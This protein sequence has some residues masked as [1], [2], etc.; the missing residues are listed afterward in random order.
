MWL[1]MTTA[2]PRSAAI[3]CSGASTA[4]TSALLWASRSPM[5]APS[6]SST[7]SRQSR[8]ASSLP[9]S[10]G[11]ASSSVNERSMTFPLRSIHR[12]DSRCSI[13]D[14]SAPAWSRRGTTVSATSSSAPISSTDPRGQGAEPS[15]QSRPVLTRAAMSSVTKLLPSPGSPNSSVIFPSATRPGHSQRTSRGST[16][17]KLIVRACGPNVS[18]ALCITNLPCLKE[19]RPR[20]ACTCTRPR[21]L[22]QTR[23]CCAGETRRAQHR[24]PNRAICSESRAKKNLFFPPDPLRQR[25][26]HRATPPPPTRSRG[27]VRDSEC[28][29]T[30]GGEGT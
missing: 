11:A 28:Q 10:T 9:R 17:A 5:N 13:R 15:G 7:S 2:S 8:I 22:Y 29:N 16:S 6:G 24:P 12:T 4:R 27:G 26:T 23:R 25:T 1:T 30:P 14:R 3:L 20:A 21:S 19:P 18:R